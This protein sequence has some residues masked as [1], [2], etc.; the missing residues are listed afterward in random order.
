M[1]KY[2]SL[3]IRGIFYLFFAYPIN[4]TPHPPQSASEGCLSGVHVKA[5]GVLLT[6]K[7]LFGFELQGLKA[8]VFGFFVVVR[9]GISL[10]SKEYDA[11]N[12]PKNSP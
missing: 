4:K 5:V 9:L 3:S 7:C 8:V 12:G 6:G 11:S 2:L 10:V 1:H